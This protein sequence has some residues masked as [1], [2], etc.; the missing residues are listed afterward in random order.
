MPKID[1]AHM[2]RTRLRRKFSLREL[3]RRAELDPFT[4]IRAEQGLVNPH[5]LT[6]AKLA[7]ALALE[8]EDLLV[9]Q[10]EESSSEETLVT[11]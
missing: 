8:V 6:V 4:V 7:D 3:G 11:T 9:E 1:G 10:E 2:R 5:L